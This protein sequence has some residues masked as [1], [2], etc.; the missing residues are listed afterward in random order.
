MHKLVPFL[1][2][3]ATLGS[4]TA[5]PP[6]GAPTLRGQAELSRLLAG[7]VAGPPQK[8]LSRYRAEHLVPIDGHTLA[9]RDGPT[10]WINHVQGNCAG[11]EYGYTLVTKPFG[12]NGPCKGDVAQVVDPGSGMLAGSCFFGDFVPYKPIAR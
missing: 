8:C 10:T 3:A 11:L 12:F 4:C 9:Y 7:K 2:T 6:P 1:I 5:V